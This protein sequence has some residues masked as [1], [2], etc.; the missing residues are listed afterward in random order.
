M[1]GKTLD[2]DD[3]FGAA[4]LLPPDRLAVAIATQ[5]D[6][7]SEFRSRWLIEKEELRNYLFAT[8]TATTSNKR[9]PW[10]NSTT[11]PKLTQIRDNLHANYM[12]A[13]FPQKNWLTWEGAGQEDE[14]KSKRTAIQ[15]YIRTKLEQDNAEVT[16][17]QLLLDYIDNGNCF[18]T[19]EWVDESFENPDT[20][21]VVRG[22]VGPRIVRISMLDMVFNPLAAKFEDAPKIIRSLITIG[23][24]QKK[25][26]NLPETDEYRKKLEKVLEA[27]SFLRGVT[28][29]FTAEDQ[30]R[31][32]AFNV[33][34]FSSYSNYLESHYVE[35]LQF[36]GDFYDIN[37]EELLEN[38]TIEVFDRAHI[39]RKEPLARWTTKPMFHHAGWRI[40]PDNLYAMGPLDNLV[41]MQYRIDHLENLKADVFDFIAFPVMKIRGFVEDFDYQPGA[42]VY[43]GDDGD[44]EFMR[45]DATALNADIQI[46][47]LERRMEELAGAPR[48][49]M[50]IRSPGEKTKFEVQQLDNAASRLFLNKVKHFEKVFLQPLLND[51]LAVARQNMQATDVIRT[52]DTEVDAVLF[53][54]VTKE[55]ITAS[56]QLRPRGASHFAQR[57][58]TLQNIVSLMNTSLVQDQQVLV[59]LSGE[60]IAK[61]IEELSDLDEFQ[62]FSKNVRIFE[63]QE[64]QALALQAQEQTE[65]QTATPPGITPADQPI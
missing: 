29:T 25:I 11:V 28:H 33:D 55:D 30:F 48:E 6:E 56:G 4:G 42:K 41:G 26:N 63:Q 51:M 57:A 15:S 36:H 58:N 59:H 35:I 2:I 49:A 7:W 62:V 43:I 61:L 12:F 21:E 9:L 47:E 1:V 53:S 5:Y 40:R 16:L 10:K 39:T 14:V 13:L 60:K 24:L 44:V 17:S 37:S 3:F 64:T 27:R 23:E 54:E 19:V 22:Y 46:Q 52:V 50:G 18:A 20:G 45:P 38:Y 31:Q 34:G 8:D 32:E 65:A